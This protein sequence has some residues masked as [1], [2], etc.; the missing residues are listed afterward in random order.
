MDPD[1]HVCLCFRVS[2]R[3]LNAFLDC[4]RPRVASQLSEC[5]GAGTG[6]HWCVP[7]LER[8]HAQW[9]AGQSP[10]LDESPGDYASRRETYRKES[11]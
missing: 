1:D 5:F 11:E 4:E 2:L 6:C 3:K 9:Q 8:L 7:F 10:S